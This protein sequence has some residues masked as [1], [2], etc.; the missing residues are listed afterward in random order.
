[1]KINNIQGGQVNEWKLAG[2]TCV[3]IFD[4]FAVSVPMWQNWYDQA[5]IPVLGVFPS[6]LSP[7]SWIMPLMKTGY[8]ILHLVA[9]FLSFL[10]RL[11]EPGQRNFKASQERMPLP[12]IHSQLVSLG[13]KLSC[14][15]FKKIIC[16]KVKKWLHFHSFLSIHN[17]WI[18]EVS[19]L[20]HSFSGSN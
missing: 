17:Q 18:R 10:F 6:L 15:T 12:L 4:S 8:C 2:L 14:Y 1:M 20:D 3:F 13:G 9:C 16:W 11:D 5:G 7:L 19:K